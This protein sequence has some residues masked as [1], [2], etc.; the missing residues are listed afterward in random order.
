MALQ[1][2]AGGAQEDMTIL[3]QDILS[4]DRD[5]NCTPPQYKPTVLLLHQTSWSTMF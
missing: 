5:L 3:S 2:L 1:Y 4:L